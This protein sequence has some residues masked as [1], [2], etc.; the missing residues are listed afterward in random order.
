MKRTLRGKFSKKQHYRLPYQDCLKVPLIFTYLLI[1]AFSGT[2]IAEGKEF[3][4]N[5]KS[6]GK[7]K[8]TIYPPTYREARE[9]YYQDESS[10]EPIRTT[11][12]TIEERIRQVFK[13]NGDEAV[14]VATC[15]S[16]LNPENIGD[17][18]L[19]FYHN[20]ELLGDSI[21][22]FQI[23]TGGRGWRRGGDEFRELMKNPDENIKYAKELYDKSGWYPWYNCKIKLGL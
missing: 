10:T 12:E 5:L 2:Y 21:G 9:I 8:I 16:Q 14:A 6:Y 7:T 18:N 4:N 22:L 23:R 17:L 1:I 19:T 20:G 15:E 13:E 11:G 3:Y